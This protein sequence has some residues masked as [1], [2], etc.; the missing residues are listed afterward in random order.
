MGWIKLHRELLE[1]PLFMQ[2]AIYIKV[3]IYCLLKGYHNSTEIDGIKVEQGSF[4]TGRFKMAEEL[5]LAP[6]T[7]YRAIKK[8]ES[9]G[10]ISINSN[11]KFSIITV[12]SWA[13]YQDDK[14]KGKSKEQRAQEFTAKVMQHDHYSK[15][16][17]QDFLGY[18]LEASDT[19]KKF[20]FE[21]QKA[22]SIERRLATWAKNA[23]RFNPAP[24]GGSKISNAMSEQER[25]LQILNG[26]LNT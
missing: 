14:K 20:R 3:F 8:L 24:A 2:D 12:S 26:N 25:A 13:K 11:N 10:H 9:S 23:Q 21:K 22:F 19:A 17:L 16:M 5:N 15:I 6:A 7:C 4:I 18:W 1:H